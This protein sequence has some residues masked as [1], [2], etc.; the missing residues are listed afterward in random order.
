VVDVVPAKQHTL[1]PFSINSRSHSATSTACRWNSALYESSSFVH[2]FKISSIVLFFKDDGVGTVT[3]LADCAVV[4]VG[5]AVVDAP[6]TVGLVVKVGANVEGA[7]GADAA[8]ASVKG[9][10]LDMILRARL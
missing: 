9:H 6:E 1:L 7:V 3:G 5:V 8:E 10:L 4:V 2:L